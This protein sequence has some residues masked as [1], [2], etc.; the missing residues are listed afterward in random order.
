M[1]TSKSRADPPN[2]SRP[3]TGDKNGGNVKNGEGRIQNLGNSYEKEG[4]R[5]F[6]CALKTV[7]IYGSWTFDNLKLEHPWLGYVVFESLFD[8]SLLGGSWTFNRAFG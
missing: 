1:R 7:L 4:T 6:G 2:V 5:R 3:P 8:V